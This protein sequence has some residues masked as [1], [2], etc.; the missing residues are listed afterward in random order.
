MVSY[1]IISFGYVGVLTNAQGKD[2][3]ST[4]SGSK[5]HKHWHT[6]DAGEDAGRYIQ[7]GVGFLPP[8]GGHSGLFVPLLPL[9]S[10]LM[11]R[12]WLLGG[13]HALPG[14]PIVTSWMKHI[15]ELDTFWRGSHKTVIT[16]KTKMN[17]G[18]H[19]IVKISYCH[20][21]LVLNS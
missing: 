13:L 20:I 6:V 11:D 21:L 14:R 12:R 5:T 2:H 7:P 18:H 15:I 9:S 10:L 3:I 19:Y 1:K 17:C 4:C 8:S 16:K